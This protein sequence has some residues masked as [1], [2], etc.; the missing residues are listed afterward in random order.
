TS[1]ARHLD[2]RRRPESNRKRHRRECM[3]RTLA[4]ALSILA[5]LAGTTAR[6]AVFLPGDLGELSREARAIVRGRVAFVAPRWSDDHRRIE[7]LVTLDTC[8]YLK[9]G[10]GDPVQFTVPGGQLGR[11]RTITVGAP[12]FAVGQQ[13]IVFLGGRGTS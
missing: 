6:G 8:A 13:V 1:S 7:T 4:A 3:T 9:G 2:G 12:E 10:L 5:T 11:Y